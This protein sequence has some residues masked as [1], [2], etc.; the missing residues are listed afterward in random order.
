MLVPNICLSITALLLVFYSAQLLENSKDRKSYP[1]FRAFVP[2]FDKIFH[3]FGL[4]SKKVIHTYKFCVDNRF[5][6]EKSLTN[7]YKI[8][9]IIWYF[10]SHR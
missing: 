8:S 1:Q 7:F 10:S 9:I 3:I 2:H 6:R 5:F 4:K